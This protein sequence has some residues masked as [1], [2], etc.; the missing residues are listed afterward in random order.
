MVVAQQVEDLGRQHPRTQLRELQDFMAVLAVR[1]GVQILIAP[2]PDRFLVYLVVEQSIT[3]QQAVVVAQTGSMKR[4][5]VQHIVQV[6]LSA[7]MASMA[8]AAVVAPVTRAIPQLMEQL[9]QT[10]PSKEQMVESVE[11]AQ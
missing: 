8:E 7:Q 1:V 3:L 9:L 6:H 2:P 5:K 11:R 10:S 4:A